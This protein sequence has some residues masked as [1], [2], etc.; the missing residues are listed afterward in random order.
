MKGQ[1]QLSRAH[2]KHLRPHSISCAK[3]QQLNQIV[4]CGAWQNGSFKLRTF[5]DDIFCEMSSDPPSKTEFQAAAPSRY[6][7]SRSCRRKRPQSI[8]EEKSKDEKNSSRNWDYGKVQEE[9]FEDS[10][11]PE[12]HIP[13]NSSVPNPES[14][15]RSSPAAEM[16]VL[17]RRVGIMNVT[18]IDSRRV[19]NSR[20][21]S[22]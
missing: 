7:P 22:M 20:T 2:G 17:W 4:H 8:W 16:I 10:E 11:Q 19:E 3:W 14:I 9:G 12:I 18:S 6:L 1:N 13:D 15:V 21:N 5:N